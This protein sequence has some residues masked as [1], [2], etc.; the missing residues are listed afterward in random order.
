MD[1]PV[2]G[3]VGLWSWEAQQG[4]MG[5]GVGSCPALS[6][7]LLDLESGVV[8]GEGCLQGSWVGS[9]MWVAG[10]EKP[11]KFRV[12]KRSMILGMDVDT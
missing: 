2:P 12:D 1:L 6:G 11:S 9:L 4:G 3:S 8:G 5:L 7:P 10:G